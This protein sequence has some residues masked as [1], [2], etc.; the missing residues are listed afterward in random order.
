MQFSVALVVCGALIAGWETIIAVRSMVSFNLA[1]LHLAFILSLLFLYSPAFPVS[2]GD[3]LGLVYTMLNNVLTAW[4]HSQSK[5][6][7]AKF[8]CHGCVRVRA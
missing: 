2:Q 6:F 5:S 8:K 3:A 1:R 7:A 4:S